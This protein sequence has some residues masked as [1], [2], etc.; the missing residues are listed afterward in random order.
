VSIPPKASGYRFIVDIL[1]ES[2]IAVGA[3]RGDPY[4]V[5][6]DGTYRERTEHFNLFKPVENL[7]RS[8]WGTVSDLFRRRED[9]NQWRFDA[10]G[11]HMWEGGAFNDVT[12]LEK[13]YTIE[14]FFNMA[15][16]YLT[17]SCY[18]FGEYVLPLVELQSYFSLEKFENGQFIPSA[19]Y[20]F[21][22]SYFA[23]RVNHYRYGASFA[24]QSAFGMIAN[25]PHYNGSGI[26]VND[27]YWKYSVNH[28]LTARDF[29]Y[30]YSAALGGHLLSVSPL[31]LAQLAAFNN[32]TVSVS[33]DL[34]DVW[35]MQ[36]GINLI[37]IDLYGLFGLRLTGLSI[38]GTGNQDFYLLQGS[39]WDTGLTG[40]QATG[41]SLI[42]SNGYINGGAV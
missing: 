34:N 24:S 37:G 23:V 15:M 8:T 40:I 33:L 19:D 28:T 12:Y 25:D 4:A 32:M 22:I 18:G 3:L 35:L 39:L 9:R 17:R 27:E 1:S 16:L 21:N 6:L 20:D 30:T 36:N 42:K 14:D 10:D 7:M 38:T 31:R 13:P 5:I 11:Q 2:D 41:V 26:D 29:N